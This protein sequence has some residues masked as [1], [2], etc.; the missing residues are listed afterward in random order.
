MVL[1]PALI[2]AV[3]ACGDPGDEAT[4]LTLATP[5][6]QALADAYVEA[7]LTGDTEAYRGLYA[8]DAVQMPPGE[9]PVEGR[10]AIV[11]RFDRVSEMVIPVNPASY[12]GLSWSPD[13]IEGDLAFDVGTYEFQLTFEDGERSDPLIGTYTVV[14]R[15]SDE[16][17]K[18]WREAWTTGPVVGS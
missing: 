7:V 6:I 4:R 5:G 12:W 13:G 2:L 1:V 17:W 14:L 18:I 8:E 11:E 3:A 10:D 15:R 9:L 16:E